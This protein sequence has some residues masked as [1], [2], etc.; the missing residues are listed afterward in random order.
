ME[1]LLLGCVAV[2]LVYYFGAQKNG[3]KRV[4]RRFSN[5]DADLMNRAKD[6]APYSRFIASV[7]RQYR[8]SRSISDKQAA[9]VE[10]AMAELDEERSERK[11]IGNV[12][13]EITITGDIVSAHYDRKGRGKA[14]RC[15]YVIY[16]DDHDIIYEGP[17][18]LAGIDAV[19]RFTATVSEHR[20]SCT[21]GAPET[22]VDG[23]RDV[24]IIK[25]PSENRPSRDGLDLSPK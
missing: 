8:G 24:T 15:R 1:W 21:V 3:G 19:V 13:G 16:S 25:R 23:V 11:Y 7:R 5:P 4:T 14:R 20:L 10:K 17:A 22:V 6:Y 18:V 2:L 12:G 9:V